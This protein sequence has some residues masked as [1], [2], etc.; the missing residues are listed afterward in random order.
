MNTYLLGPRPALAMIKQA[1]PQSPQRNSDRIRFE[2]L[3]CRSCLPLQC[4]QL[5]SQS[6]GAPASSDT[7]LAM[8]VTL[9]CMTRMSRTL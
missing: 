9:A 6:F 4:P 7:A 2:G 8:L 3:G 1:V 5:S